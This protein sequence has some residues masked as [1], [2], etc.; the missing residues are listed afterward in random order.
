MRELDASPLSSFCFYLASAT[1]IC[2]LY[3]QWI[4]HLPPYTFL[5]NPHQ[6]RRQDLLRMFLIPVTK[7][8]WTTY[9]HICRYRV[10]KQAGKTL[11]ITLEQ[12]HQLYRRFLD[13]KSTAEPLLRSHNWAGVFTYLI[14][15]WV[16]SFHCSYNRWYLK[17]IQSSSSLDSSG[18]RALMEMRER[19]SLLE[20]ENTRLTFIEQEKNRIET[21]YITLQC[22]LKL[23]LI[24]ITY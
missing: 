14:D 4:P 6:W 18:S 16:Y 22:V 15:L 12:A 21:Q 1:Y 9:R 24:F 3:L 2:C 13:R 20:Q 5:R 11:L 7:I 19:L 8:L 17:Y 23:I 10:L